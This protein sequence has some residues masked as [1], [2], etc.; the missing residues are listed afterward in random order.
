ME[1]VAQSRRGQPGRWDRLRSWWSTPAWPVEAEP[2]DLGRALGVLGRL[3]VSVGV[4]ALLLA[5]ISAGSHA[6]DGAPR[7]TIRFDDGTAVGMLGFLAAVIIAINL[8][9]VA[10]ETGRRTVTQAEGPRCDILPAADRAEFLDVMA[11]ASASLAALIGWFS[12]LHDF[13]T[14]ALY[15]GLATA[16]GSFIV[17]LFAVMA[18]FTKNRL[19]PTREANRRAAVA[20]REHLAALRR[21][22]EP[23]ASQPHRHHTL[24]A[25]VAVL[26]GAVL[27][28]HSSGS[29][30]L[31]LIAFGLIVGI[32][33]LVAPGIVFD[34]EATRSRVVPI[35]LTLASG[36]LASVAVSLGLVFLMEWA[37][38]AEGATAF[39][40]LL[41]IVLSLQFALPALV[42]I[43]TT[44]AVRHHDSRVRDGMI[45]AIARADTA[46]ARRLE[47]NSPSPRADT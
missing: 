33:C 36:V 7:F 32:G 46:S 9:L 26:I 44:R 38:G 16:L 37:A 21:D 5:L 20:A 10:Q 40:G 34:S 6:I 19:A 12:L 43:S 41:L 27:A 47:E 45:N 11:F 2:Y 25:G 23:L 14:I 22:W 35:F 17:V 42:T 1:Q 39:A 8:D 4:F 24:A 29:A 30:H 15:P 3:Y 28:W 31:A 13:P 18:S